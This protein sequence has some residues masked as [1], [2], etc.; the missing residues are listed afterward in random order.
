MRNQQAE[1]VVFVKYEEEI[2]G[3]CMRVLIFLGQQG[4]AYTKK[5]VTRKRLREETGSGQFPFIVINGEGIGGHDHLVRLSG[6]DC[7]LELILTPPPISGL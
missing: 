6:R 2:T 1:I 3:C 5:P 4:L 7:F